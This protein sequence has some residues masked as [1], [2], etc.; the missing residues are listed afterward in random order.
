MQ[1]LMKKLG[2]TFKDESLLATA[3]TH[4]SFANENKK[5]GKS[6]ER[7]EF[8][9]DS[10][11]SFIVSTYIYN[12]FTD[13]PEGGLSKMRA[14]LVCEQCLAKCSEKLDLGK[15]II[16]SK[17]EAMTGGR[18]R[19]SIL[20]DVMEAIIAAIYLDGGID[21]AREFTLRTLESSIEQVRKGKGAFKDY[22]TALQEEVQQ[23]DSVVEY[24][25]IKEEGPEHSKIFTVEVVSNGKKLA[26]GR[27]RSKKDAEQDA[28]HK[29]LERL[30]NEK[31]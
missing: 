21:A 13:M 22:K 24:I 15:H 26:V 16:L 4:S 18:T 9:G 1:E 5:K 10:I 31:V 25:H 19:P 12:N 28:A 3:L 11:L 20:A 8:L 6:Y 27:G 7:L 2:Y 17:G 30:A 23:R 14:A 29:A